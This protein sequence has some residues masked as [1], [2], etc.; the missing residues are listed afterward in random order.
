M[1]KSSPTSLKQAERN[2][3]NYALNRERILA[4]KKKSRDANKHVYNARKRAYRALNPDAEHG[5]YLR[6]KYG[7]TM[8]QYTAML[9]AQGGVCAICGGGDGSR[10]LAVDH[11]HATGKVR[12]LLC[13]SCNTSLGR[14]G[15]DP[16]VLERA[17]AYLRKHRG[18]K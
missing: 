13:A 1:A 11:C 8:E 2:R 10:R 18:E 4:T 9:A 17:A 15:E 5:Y 6:R 12:A 14:L 7:I 3:R 16:V